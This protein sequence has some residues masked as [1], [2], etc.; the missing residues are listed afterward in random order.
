MRTGLARVTSSLPVGAL[1]VG[2]QAVQ[3]LSTRTSAVASRNAAHTLKIQAMQSFTRASRTGAHSAGQVDQRRGFMKFFEKFGFSKE[4][5]LKKE[6]EAHP[7]DAKIQEQYNAHLLENNPMLLI[8][9]FETGLYAASQF[10]K[11]MYVSALV[12]LRKLNRLDLTKLGKGSEET[13]ALLSAAKGTKDAPLYIASIEPSNKQVLWKLARTVLG[14][15]LMIVAFLFILDSQGLGGKG[16]GMGLGKSKSFEPDEKPKMTFDDVRGAD[17]AK[18]DLQ[19]LVAYLKDPTK[20]SKLGGKLPAGVLMVGPP[21]TGKTLLAR[22]V[23]GEAEVPFFYAAG[24]EFDEMFVGVGARR[25]REL[26][27]AARKA[28][29]CIVFIDEI[30]AVGSKRGPREQSTT[31]MTI[32]QLL[33]EIDGYNPTEGVI[34]IGATNDPDSLDAAL[35]R[36]GRFDKIVKVDNPTIKGRLDILKLHSRGIPLSEQADL[37][38]IARGTIGF[39]GAS[40]ANLVN[41]AALAAAARGAE[42]VSHD[43]LEQ[44]RDNILMGK[45]RRSYMMLDKEKE[46]TAWHEAGHTVMAYFNKFAMPLHKVTILPRGMALG[47][48]QQLPD[49]DRVSESKA[50][51]LAQLD[52][53]LGGRV[54]EEM[55][56]GE[57]GVT[58]GASNDF[59]KATDVAYRMVTKYG[60]SDKVGIMHI[61]ERSMEKL[62]PALRE[63]VEGEVRRLIAESLERTRRMLKDKRAELKGLADGLLEKETLDYDEIRETIDPHNK[64]NRPKPPSISLS[65]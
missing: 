46:N 18:E 42:E 17:E 6:A 23:S 7:A 56:N 50:E 44:A 25:I 53:L 16:M 48:T 14:A 22:A 15:Y 58:G 47:M 3:A 45:E 12:K 28:A 43:D 35:T 30:D 24:S 60:F 11:E 41:Q 9:R 39:S 64:M 34:L 20:F 1:R 26:F 36:P 13:L 21:G 29:P 40:L 8:E 32:N 33:S 38:K 37:E 52:I 4:K 55:L 31:R 65:D 51:M 54:A 10:S 2:G 57:E 5:K 19:E 63:T 62:S 61:D 59:M 49:R 27:A